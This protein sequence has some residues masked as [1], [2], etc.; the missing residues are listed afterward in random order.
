ME[1]HGH[2]IVT[3]TDL[4]AVFQDDV[5]DRR[6]TKRRRIL[7]GIVLALLVGLLGAAGYV[8]LGVTR[9]EIRLEFLETAGS[10]DPSA[11]AEECPAGPF[12]YQDPS[13]ITVDVFNSTTIDGLAGTAAGQLRERAFAVRTIG[14]REAPTTAMIAE[15]VSG[16]AGRANA[17]TLQRN[18]PGTTYRSDDRDDRS[19]DVILGSG[20]DGVV[21]EEGLDITPAGLTCAEDEDS[22]EAPEAG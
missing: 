3:E 4:G 21:P 14:N 15:I 17:F 22:T 12:D 10:P 8:A 20:Y 9:G 1:W 5:V 6:R 13:S 7:H 19:V 11:A 16:E 18:L 2:H